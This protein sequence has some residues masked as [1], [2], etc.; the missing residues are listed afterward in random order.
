M[1]PAFVNWTLYHNGMDTVR[2]AIGDNLLSKPYVSDLMRLNKSFIVKRG[3]KGAREKLAAAKQLSGY[4]YHS[5]HNDQQSVWLAQREG[6]AKDGWDQTQPAVIKMLTV[7]KQKEQPISDYIKELQIVPVSISYELIP[8]DE[9]MA[10]ELFLKE[11]EGGYEKEEHEDVASIATGINGF[12]GKVHVHYGSLLEGSFDSAEAVSDAIDQ[13]VV[14]GYRLFSSN[15]YAYRQLHGM[16]PSDIAWA[17]QDDDVSED[18]FS[19]R[20]ESMDPR[21]RSKVL[22]MYANPVLAKLQHLQRHAN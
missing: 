13:Q 5:I 15:I 2:I 11:Q 19:A 4:I 9:V 16:E 17:P 21:W 7:G 12:K 14:N 20:I 10:R 1:D 8:C 6:R 22:A 3:L 18:V